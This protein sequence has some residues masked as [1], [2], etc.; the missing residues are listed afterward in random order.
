[1]GGGT[2]TDDDDVTPYW[3]SGY[4]GRL[5]H[6]SGPIW[7]V[8]SESSDNSYTVDLGVPKCT[9]TDWATKRNRLV[10]QAR[11]AGKPD[12]SVK[13]ECKHV[14]AAQKV[15]RD[16]GD[17]GEFRRAAEAK[18]EADRI[19]AEFAAKKTKKDALAMLKDLKEGR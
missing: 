11:A 17:D 5:D 16:V 7:R 8:F 1:M 3:T 14:R 10:S 13:Y 4:G 19:K 2:G 15:A 18:Q 6:V 12:S 9:C